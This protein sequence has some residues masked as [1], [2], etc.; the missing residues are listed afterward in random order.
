MA[1]SSA[2]PS[3]FDRL[4]GSRRAKRL[5]NIALG[6]SGASG[7]LAAIFLLDP[8]MSGEPMHTAIF[9]A[10]GLLFFVSSGLSVY[11]HL[12]FLSRD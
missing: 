12:K 3:P 1:R 8:I 9:L 5:R 7:F 11:Y 10:M 6:T 4:Y 2:S